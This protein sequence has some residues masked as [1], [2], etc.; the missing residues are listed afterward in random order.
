MN[1]KE[2]AVISI[3]LVLPIAL[4][5]SARIDLK[6]FRVTREESRKIGLFF[7]IMF[8]LVY[9]FLL[10]EAY[11]NS[12]LYLFNALI[13]EIILLLIISLI[14]LVYYEPH[15]INPRLKRDYGVTLDYIRMNGTSKFLQKMD[16]NRNKK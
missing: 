10:I 11:L 4:F 8:A 3:A 5:I 14:T 2:I 16:G 7:L 6:R 13:V 9:L 12:V 1:Y 15:V